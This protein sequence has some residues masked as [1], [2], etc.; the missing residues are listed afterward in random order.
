MEEPLLQV[1]C[2]SKRFPGVLALD[3]VDLTVKR[4]EVMALVG[5]NG[6]GKSTLMKI[7]SGVYQP[8]GGTIMMD[9]EPVVPGNPVNARDELGISIIYQEFNL[10]LNLSVAENIY[11]GRMPTRNGFVRFDS[12][13]KQASTFLN[14]LG[15]D[16]NPRTRV[17]KLS[18]A[19]QQMV[20]IAKAIS[21]DAR[22]LIMDEPT[23]ALTLHETE[24]LLDVTRGLRDEGVGIIFITHR[25]DEVFQI[26]DRVTVLRDG[27]MVG[28]HPIQD[29][30]RPELVRL[31]VDRDLS[32]L[33]PTKD[34]EIGP[35]LLEVQ[36]L[37]VPKKLYD[38]SFELRKG[39]IVGIFGLLGAGRTELAYALFGSGP[40]PTG[41][42]TLNGQ[43]AKIRSSVGATVA[44]IGYVPEDRKL[45]GLILP[46]TVRENIT[47]A[48]L[49]KLSS[50]TFVQSS[51]ERKVADDFI[52]DLQIRT[53][54]REQKV[55]N[56]SGGNQQKVVLAKWLANKPNVLI[57][58]EP[59]RGIDVGAKAEV[60]EIMAQLAAQGQGILMIS[61]DMPEVLGMSDRIL[62][63]HEGHLTAEFSREHAT[64]E[65]V[66]LAATGTFFGPD[67]QPVEAVE[68][69]A[70]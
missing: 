29:M 43:P 3:Q 56:L 46:M 61:S 34:H 58:D 65:K 63:M 19:Q 8:D 20:E 50:G 25:L 26:A 6:A 10:A 36:D 1:C 53:P 45:Q 11:L 62:V 31:M 52:D 22:L 44:G 47:L 28:D 51:Q 13:Y 38:I 32:S 42:V 35:P 33:Y 27:K 59:T 41:E 37:S 30:N 70:V 55:K 66:M 5:E 40:N 14:R 39:E 21:Y 4:G 69:A 49:R 48:A 68:A 7:L 23:A 15:T 67:G 57:L 2:V 64:K 18:V 16:L 17:A 60:H 12:L 9:G 54:S 24:I